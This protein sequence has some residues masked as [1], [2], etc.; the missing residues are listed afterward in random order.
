MAMLEVA[1]RDA[2]GQETLSVRLPRKPSQASQG[3]EDRGGHSLIPHVTVGHSG[4]RAVWGGGWAESKRPG[5]PETPSS[6][7]PQA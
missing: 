2:Y 7:P 6:Q 4:L 5:P 3:L 1:C